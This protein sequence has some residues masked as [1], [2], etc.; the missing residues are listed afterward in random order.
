[1]HQVF[2]ISLLINVKMIREGL[3]TGSSLYGGIIK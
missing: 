2:Q 3:E 1:M